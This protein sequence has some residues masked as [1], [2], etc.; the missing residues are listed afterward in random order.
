MLI[1]RLFFSFGIYIF[2]TL[3]RACTVESVLF[4][5]FWTEVECF[6]VVGK[7]IFVSRALERSRV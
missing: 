7:S 3:A 4:L 2:S 6:D 5:L 1:V